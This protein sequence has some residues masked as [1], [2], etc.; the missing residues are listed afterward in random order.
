MENWLPWHGQLIR[1]P[2]TVDDVAALV[3]VT[4]A[5]RPERVLGGLVTT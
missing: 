4:L 2:S 3:R 1:P 5:E